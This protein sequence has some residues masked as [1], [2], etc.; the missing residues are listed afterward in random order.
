MRLYLGVFLLLF[1]AAA[2]G[3][4]MELG[5]VSEDELKEKAYP[6][7]TSA[8]AAIIFKKAKSKFKYRKTTGFYMEH[9]YEFRIKIYKKEGLGWGTF[10]VPY[11][12]GYKGWEDDNVLFSNA[13]TYNLEN[14]KIVK[15]KAGAEGRFKKKVN[16]L[17]D[18][19]TLVLPN[20]KVGSVIEF[21][22]VLRT[23][24]VTEF[25]TFYFQYEI[26]MK[27]CV[28]NTV[29]PEYF[30]YK[31]LI[32]GFG[33]VFNAAKVVPESQYYENQYNQSVSFM[34]NAVSR[35]FF[36]EDV[37]ALKKE[38]FVDNLQ[39]YRSAVTHELEK[40]Q[41]PE[42]PAKQ[43]ATT[44][45]AVALDIYKNENFGKPLRERQ[46]FESFLEPYIKSS[47]APMQ[48]ATAVFNFVQRTMSWDGHYG[49]LVDKG[50]KKAFSDKTGN[51]A[52]INLMLVAML[53]HAGV[54]A[55]PVLVSTVAN[56]VAAYPTRASFNCV[57]ASAEID[58]KIM[59]FD[60]TDKNVWPG[61][62]P[63]RD[64][65]WYGWRIANDGGVKQVELVPNKSSRE[66][67]TIVA[68]VDAAGKLQGKVR[69]SRTDYHALDFRT[70]YIGVNQEDYLR[71]LEHRYNGIEVSAYKA[72]VSPDKSQPIE[73]TF[74]FSGGSVEVI[75]DK[76]YIDPF[77][78]LTD[79]K[80]PFVTEQRTLPICFGFPTLHKRN[81]NIE[82]P[83]GYA[84]ASLPKV[85]SLVL[86]EG[87]GA[88]SVNVQQKGNVI[89]LA[90][91]SEIKLAIVDAKFYPVLKKYFGDMA[92]SAAEK[93]V[94]VKL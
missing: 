10:S 2:F 7:D 42:E 91:S 39:N 15:T 35:D 49:Y 6:A 88:Y 12:T 68:A 87:V 33:S 5:K 52:E 73:E 24:D 47:D 79:T 16:E 37:P 78:F 32:L 61:V 82:I 62:L 58:G 56:G 44:W 53:N 22:Y 65:N 34:Y 94:L 85:M 11:Y 63:F 28:Y 43:Y 81:I 9:E 36:A 75:G 17:W 18:E 26:P 54:P 71:Q 93:I 70:A 72:D 3:Q 66:A 8:P 20:V 29:M 1:S 83:A 13:V 55:Y 21:K 27:H 86:P 30:Q 4:K 48:K 67:F 50:V 40:T 14:G 59:L 80:N 90:M 19:A 25:P 23:E 92:Q 41:F 57:I 77:L 89:Q 74:D 76:M 64:L 45:E 46:Y 38:P 51:I 60:A 69:L 84:V 31:P